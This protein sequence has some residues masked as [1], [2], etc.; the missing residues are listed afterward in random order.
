MGNLYDYFRAPDDAAVTAACRASD[1]SSPVDVGPR[2]D[3][4]SLKRIDVDALGAL[5]T[6]VN[7]GRPVPV[8]AGT[9]WPA[10]PAPATRE[11]WRALPH[12][13]PWITGPWTEALAPAAVD[14]LAG[15]DDARVTE[16]GLA[17]A[18]AIAMDRP[19]PL[20]RVAGD[21]V[22]LARRAR[23]AGEVLYLW[24]SL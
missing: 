14:V 19:D 21:L 3:G 5:L 24:A 9:V 17:W 6:V 1:G 12:D 23:R 10:D 7:H 2:F 11:D 18:E 15:V 20:I 4:L 13:A 8:T 22:A 16:I